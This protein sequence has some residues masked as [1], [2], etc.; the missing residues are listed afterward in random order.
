MIVEDEAILALDLAMTVEAAGAIVAGPLHRLDIAM[1]AEALHELD[2]AI[3]DVDIQGAE[4]FP[5]ADR[6]NEAGV[7]IV[8]HTGRTDVQRFAETYHATICRKPC[9]SDRL[10]DVLESVVQRD[11]E[12]E[13]EQRAAAS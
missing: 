9:V 1:R 4:V 13:F 6:L 8:F 3:L 5:F 2:A 12:Q 7:P 11:T 10:I